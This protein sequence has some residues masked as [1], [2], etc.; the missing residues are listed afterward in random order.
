VRAWG[1]SLMTVL[2]IACGVA[3]FAAISAIT[4]DLESQLDGAAGQ[5]RVELVISERRATS[6]MSSRMSTAAMDALAAH[7]W[8]ACRTAGLRHAQRVVEPVCA[9]R[10]RATRTSSSAF[11]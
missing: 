1:R 6:P 2:G 7:L 11:R 3:L 10:R 9:D 5:Y 8:R 4:H